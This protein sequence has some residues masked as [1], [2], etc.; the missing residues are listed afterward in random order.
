M[1]YFWFPSFF[2]KS[3]GGS[4]SLFDSIAAHWWCW[5]AFARLCKPT[6]SIHNRSYCVVVTSGGYP[7][8][9]FRSSFTSQLLCSGE[10]S[11]EKPLF[12]LCVCVWRR[13]RYMF[14]LLL[15]LWTEIP[16]YR[17][18]IFFLSWFLFSFLFFPPFLFEGAGEIFQSTSI[19]VLVV[20][21]ILPFL[22][23]IDPIVSP[24]CWAPIKQAS[25]QR[26]GPHSFPPSLLGTLSSVI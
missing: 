8:F 9:S 24:V 11:M 17:P 19:R 2:F 6:A 7:E 14:S 13:E 5:R 20:V 18:Y 12:V 16:K 21:M 1:I 3:E 10:W 22:I 26:N 15:N 23:S 25:N 4:V